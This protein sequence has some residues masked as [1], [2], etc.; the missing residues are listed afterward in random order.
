M[1]FFPGGGVASI[2]QQSGECA[3]FTSDG[4]NWIGSGGTLMNRFASTFFASLASNG[5]Q[6]LPSGLIIQWGVFNPSPAGDLTI[7]FPI[8]FTAAP[9]EVCVSYVS[10]TTSEAVF[11]ASANWTATTAK[12]ATWLS[13]SATRSGGTATW[14]AIGK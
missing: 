7:T 14:F 6:K 1:F 11:G 5:Y 9:W 4:T 8:A 3:E 2:T 12:M 13:S 10:P